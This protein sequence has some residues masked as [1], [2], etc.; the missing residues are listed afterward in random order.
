MMNIHTSYQQWSSNKTDT[1][2]TDKIKP[3]PSTDYRMSP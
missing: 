3:T 1:A 2:F